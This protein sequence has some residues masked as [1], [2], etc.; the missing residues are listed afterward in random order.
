MWTQSDWKEEDDGD[1]DD[2]D[3]GDE[4][5]DDEEYDLLH[6]TCVF[7]LW[8]HLKSHF[9]ELKVDMVLVDM[10]RAGGY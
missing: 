3:G 7:V 4:Q 10:L 6:I 2:D 1:V 5:G 9:E 8:V